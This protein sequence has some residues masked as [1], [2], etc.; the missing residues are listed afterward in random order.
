MTIEEKAKAY[1]EALERAKIWQNHLYDTNDKDYADELNY[2]FPELRE[3]EDEKIRNTLI[4]YFDDA[5]KA[6]ENP[7]QSYGI[8]TDKIIAWLEKQGEHA[9][10]LS[11]IQVGDKV[12]RNEGGVLVNISQL[13]RVA[14]PRRVKPVDKVEPKFKVGDWVSGYYTNYKVTAINSEGYMVEDT[15][16][17]KINILFENENFHHLWT[18]RDAKDGDV[19]VVPPAKGSEHT[20]Q[21]FIFKEIKD[22][23]YVKNAVEYYCRVLDNEFCVNERGFMGQSDYYFVP[24]TK[25]QCDTLFAK[26]H[27]AGYEW[28]AEKKELK[29]IESAEWSEEDN[30]FMYDTLS[31]L[32]ELKDRYGKRYGNVG[33]C[34]DWLKSLKQRIEK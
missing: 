24:A 3:S 18:I 7:L 14:K 6:D 21:I 19:L 17:N 32:T 4:D 34:I 11:K 28:D 5:N 15:V 2:I 33:M 13:E 1:D 8:H 22:R 16:G 9:N 29:K 23:E 12:T 20:E 27:E 10:F 25:K 31:N 30:I 26:M